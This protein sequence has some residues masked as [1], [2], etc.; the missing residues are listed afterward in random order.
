MNVNNGAILESAGGSI[1]TNSRIGGLATA[2]HTAR[3]LPAACGIGTSTINNGLTL[4]DMPYSNFDFQ[5]LTNFDNIVLGGWALTL[6]GLHDINIGVTPIPA[7]TYTLATYSSLAGAGSVQLGINPGGTGTH[8]IT[9]G[10]NALTLQVIPGAL[11]ARL[12]IGGGGAPSSKAPEP[13]TAT[14]APTSP[15]FPAATARPSPAPPTLPCSSAM[16]E[17]PPPVE[18]SPS[19]AHRVGGEL[20]FGVVSPTN[21]YIIGDGTTT[22]TLTLAGGVTANSNA[23]INAPVA[24][25]A[26]Q[27]MKTVNG[28]TLG[29]AGAISDWD[30]PRHHHQD[31]RRRPRPHRQQHLLRRNGHQR[32]HR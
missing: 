29:I 31:R 16:A 22:N 25:E 32:G 20:I 19:A 11:P 24:L 26:S 9:A 14:A 17:L 30:R 27:T 2:E 8:S 18:P 21:P 28:V 13:A 7:G 6:N 3:L 5:S 1:T 10:A 4:N 12:G 15:I 23:G